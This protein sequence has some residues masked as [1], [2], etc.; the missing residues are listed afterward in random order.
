MGSM[1]ITQQILGDFLGVAWSWMFEPLSSK[2]LVTFILRD[3]S[4]FGDK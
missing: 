1:K 2:P 3:L 4:R